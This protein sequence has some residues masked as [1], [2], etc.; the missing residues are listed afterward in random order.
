[1]FARFVLKRVGAAVLLVFGI[2]VVTFALTALLP[3]DPAAAQL[4]DRASGDPAIVEAYRKAHGLDQ[5]LWTQFVL[6]LVHLVQGDLG[7]SLQSRNPVLS[8]LAQFGPASFELA[9]TATAIAVIVGVGLGILA[10]LRANGPLDHTLRVVSLGGVSIPIF[11]LSLIAVFL[12]STQ[13]RLF[14]SSGRLNPG[15]TPPNHITGLYVLDSIITANWATLGSSVAHL[16]LPALVLAAP[17][18]GLLLRFTR[19]S[20][21]EV[22]GN[23][24]VR[25]AN[26]KGLPA[27]LVVRRHILRGALVPVIT[28]LGS[29]F[30][31]LLAGTVLVEQI[32]AWPGIGSYAYRSAS[33]LDLP[34]IVGVTLF[35]AIVFIL[36]NFLVD[37]LYGLIDPRIRTS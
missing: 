23:D 19:S 16:I 17:M 11:W 3:G 24:Y 31:S 35:V 12:F 6:Y 29:A 8:D 36:V 4:G 13:L 5:P 14:P 30:A 37:I 10:A 26:A 9:V 21:L 28:V 27:G 22:I 18:V 7:T 1:M 33:N 2:V 32:F 15:E 34:A 25:S 20:M